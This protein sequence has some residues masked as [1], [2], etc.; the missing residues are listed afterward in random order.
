[1]NNLSHTV[2]HCKGQ[3]TSAIGILVLGNF[4]GPSY[5]GGEEPTEQQVK[6]LGKLINNLLSRENL[7]I[8]K[9]EVY[10]HKDFGKENCPGTTLGTFVDKFKQS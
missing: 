6:S 4:D 2:W 8:S 3:N 1:M 9:Q 5:D 7:S 10:G